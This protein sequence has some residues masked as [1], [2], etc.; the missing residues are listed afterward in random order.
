MITIA[1]DLANVVLLDVVEA[2][3]ELRRSGGDELFI[4]GCIDSTPDNSVGGRFVAEHYHGAVERLRREWGDPFWEGPV[5]SRGSYRGPAPW[6]RLD[7]GYYRAI[8]AAW[9]RRHGSWSVVMVT[10]HDAGSIVTL[11]IAIQV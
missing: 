11:D 10:S 9:W 6:P 2:F 3:D 1:A 5:G 4:G 7:G 8:R